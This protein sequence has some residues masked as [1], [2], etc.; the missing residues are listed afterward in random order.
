MTNQQALTIKEAS[1]LFGIFPRTT[2]KLSPFDSA[3][4]IVGVSFDI[5]QMAYAIRLSFARGV[6]ATNTVKA[7]EEM[8]LYQKL[9]LLISVTNNCETMN[10]VPYFLNKKLAK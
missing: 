10:D 5:K 4:I 8:S 7:I 9:G 1:E 3:D 2:K 6:L